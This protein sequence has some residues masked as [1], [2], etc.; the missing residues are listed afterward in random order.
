MY[1]LPV[2]NSNLPHT[3]FINTSFKGIKQHYKTSINVENDVFVNKS[4]PAFLGSQKETEKLKKAKQYI[5]NVN[6]HLQKTE[7]RNVN[8]LYD[9]NPKQI[10]GILDDIEV[11]KG[12]T[13]YDL[14]LM[15]NMEWLLFQRGCPE[16]ECSHCMFNAKKETTT[17]VWDNLVKLADG[18]GELIERLGFNPFT[19]KKGISPFIDSDPLLLKSYDIHGGVH[20]IAEAQELFYDRT[21]LNFGLITAGWNPENIEHQKAANDLVDLFKRKPDSLSALNISL[22][23]F[24]KIMTDSINSDNLQDKE[25]YK[26]EYIDRMTNVIITFLPVFEAKK[27]RFNFEF[28]N[29]EYVNDDSPYSYKSTEKLVNEIMDNVEKKCKEKE[30]KEEGYSFLTQNRNFN[31]NAYFNVFCILPTGRA[32]SFLKDT[33]NKFAYKFKKT[34]DGPELLIEDNYINNDINLSLTNTLLNNIRF[35]KNVTLNVDLTKTRSKEQ[36]NQYVNDIVKNCSKLSYLF[37]YDKA[38]INIVSDDDSKTERFL[39]QLKYY[40]GFNIDNNYLDEILN[41]TRFNEVN[42]SEYQTAKSPLDLYEAVPEENNNKDVF[43]YR[44]LQQPKMLNTNGKVFVQNG[45][46]DG[47]MNDKTVDKSVFSIRGIK[48]HFNNG[49][50]M[51][52]SK[53]EKTVDVDRSKIVKA[54][55]AVIKRDME[56]NLVPKY[57]TNYKTE[58]KISFEKRFKAF[59]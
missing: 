2:N 58:N 43:L 11:F 31:K 28:A 23:P 14:Y 49:I 40:L 30:I 51:K 15:N 59:G 52:E 9:L 27:A 17:M 39:S 36:Y 33:S 44:I 19:N 18:M 6:E 4:K 22:H 13:V 29:D 57:P 16:S 1:T 7:N 26:K 21:K 20:N 54:D 10:E 53:L 46:N 12:L 37:Y 41:N 56:Y 32:K 8:S 55:K 5:K 48:L 3:S 42:P 45:W 50:V 25:K 24:H 38:N 34:P 47:F 35:I